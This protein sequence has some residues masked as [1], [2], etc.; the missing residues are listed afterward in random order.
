MKPLGQYKMD[1]RAE[2]PF[3]NPKDEMRHGRDVLSVWT[4]FIPDKSEGFEQAGV[5]C[6]NDS[7]R[8]YVWS[9]LGSLAETSSSILKPGTGFDA[10]KQFLAYVEDAIASLVDIPSSIDR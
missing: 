4:T 10:Q 5:E 6:L 2:K 1:H 8:T 7:V 9:I 3:F